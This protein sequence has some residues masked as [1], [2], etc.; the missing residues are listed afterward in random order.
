MLIAGMHSS[1]QTFIDKVDPFTKA[2]QRIA[3]VIIYP[4]IAAQ[5]PQLMFYENDGKKYISFFWPSMLSQY[6]A[7]HPIKASQTSILMQM[8]GDSILRFKA[9]TT[10][11][12]IANNNL[13]SAMAITT[14]LISD[15]Q[16][17]YLI[18]NKVHLLRWGING[19]LGPDI[20][21]LNDSKRK[22]IQK[23]AAWILGMQEVSSEEN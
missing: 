16:L 18:T 10:V 13:F 6:G 9:D 2:H 23:A 17:Q 1:A 3:T 19:D 14:S 21:D 7:A 20:S 8:D 15:Q 4:L 12:A 22:K 5:S 11:S